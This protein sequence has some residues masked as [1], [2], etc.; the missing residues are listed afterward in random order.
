[1]IS[2]MEK[3]F[4]KQMGKPSPAAP[5]GLSFISLAMQDTWEDL[6]KT[7]GAGWYQDGFAYLFGEGLDAFLPC[8]EAWSFV[9]PKIKNPMILGRNAYGALLVVLDSS[10]S[11][12]RLALL[13]PTRITWWTDP[14][15]TLG[16]L[17]GR[18]IPQGSLPHFFEREP[19]QAWRRAG[20]RRLEVKEMLAPRTAVALGG[21]MSPDNFQIA[22]VVTY[23]QAS[24]PVYAKTLRALERK[25]KGPK[26]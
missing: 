10:S 1:V 16:S 19:Y 15:L 2:E 4:R 7:I 23:Y 26:R 18:F 22:D 5:S 11:N 25:K 6:H 14:S 21:T 9:A 12:P 8:L 13:D 3:A 20:G 24:G 17:I